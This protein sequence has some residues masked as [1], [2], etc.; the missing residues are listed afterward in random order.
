M[1]GWHTVKVPPQFLQKRSRGRMAICPLCREAYPAQDGGICRGC[2]GEAPYLTAG[3]GEEAGPEGP[4]LK[5]LPL[6]ETVGRRALHDM[7]MI[8]PGVSKG[9]AFE[10]GQ[11][12]G[13]GDLCRLQHIDRKST[14]LNSSHG[15]I[16]DAVF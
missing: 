14:R 5:R 13:V 16:S 15:Y 9:P 7:T 2:Q 12:I 11:L 6:A 4:A 8:V 1:L 3:R 10:K